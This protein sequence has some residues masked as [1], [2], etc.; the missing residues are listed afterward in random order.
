MLGR[1][2][3]FTTEGGTSLAIEVAGRRFLRVTGATGLD[4]AEPCLAAAVL[5]D[6]HKDNLIKLLQA[7]AKPRHEIRL[8]TTPSTQV[9]EGISVGLPVALIADLLLVELNGLDAE[10]VSDATPPPQDEQTA[11]VVGIVEGASTIGRF[12]RANGPVLMAWMILGGE[13]DGV[14]EG[15]EEM[16]E[17]LKGFLDD[18]IRDLTSQLDRLSTTPGEPICLGLGA[19]LSE[20][21]TLLCARAEGSVLLGLAE[22]DCTQTLMQ[23]WVS[24]LR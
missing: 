14:F 12:A 1:T 13:E 2:L 15:P 10:V 7:L 22:G 6:E 19:S 21:H 17:H 11:P 9:A 24:A 20:G 18:E 4:G 5:E 23:A 8:V 16:V 3:Q